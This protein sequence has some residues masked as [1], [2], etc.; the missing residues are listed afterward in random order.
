[1]RACFS[2][3]GTPFAE[4]LRERLAALELKLVSGTATRQEKAEYTDLR[5]KLPD[6]IGEVAD[7][8]LRMVKR[9]SRSP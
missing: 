1:M 3:R 9:A 5:S 2:D 4:R 7:R 8:K 6:D